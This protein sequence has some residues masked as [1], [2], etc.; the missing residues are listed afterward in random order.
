MSM[1]RRSAI[2]ATDMAC[3]VVGRYRVVRAS[4]FVLNR[5]RRDVPSN[6][7]DSDGEL[8]LQRWVLA[9]SQSGQQVHVVDVGA[10]VGQWS[11]GIISAARQADRRDDLDLHAFEPSMYTFEQ[12]CSSFSQ[13][14]L[15]LNRLAIS[16]KSGAATLHVIVPGGGTNSLHRSHDTPDSTVVE[17]VTMTTLDE[18]ADQ[19]GLKQITLLKI[20]TEGND[21]AVLRGAQTLLSS[22][23]ISVIQFEYNRW[24]V[25]A[26]SFLRDAFDLFQPLG[27]QIGKLTPWGVEF[28][29]GWHSDLETF[30]QGNYVAIAPGASGWVPTVEWWKSG[31]S[32]G[33]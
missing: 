1:I 5:A 14:R 4:R 10:N 17:T 31:R 18:Y 12:L 13:E 15:T 8:S 30:V 3:R 11:S 28:Y 24:W 9:A 2:L 20:D 25:Y 23:R 7:V 16:D 19:A 21:M 6:N 29:P 32:S 33:R 27:Y 22:Q 26:R